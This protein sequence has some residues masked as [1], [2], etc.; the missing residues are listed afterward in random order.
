MLL[1]LFSFLFVIILV[2]V[3]VIVISISNRAK[4][5]RKPKAFTNKVDRLEKGS[6]VSSSRANQDFT[7][8]RNEF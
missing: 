7:I 4:S 1:F 6:P 8:D 2:V 3:V 5:N